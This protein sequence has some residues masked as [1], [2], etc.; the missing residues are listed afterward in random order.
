MG[1]AHA[2]RDQAGPNVNHIP[3]DA[4][5]YGVI[6]GI[7]HV[8]EM[9]DGPGHP[10]SNY[11]WLHAIM[12]ACAQR[13]VGVLLVGETGN[14]TVSYAGNGS[15]LRSLLRGQHAWLCNCSCMENQ[16]PGACSNARCS[17]RSRR[18]RGGIWRA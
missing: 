10:V 15:A 7:E 2:T 5:D 4:R 9:H 3:I 11:F 18:R 14:F 6:A 17:S 12:D 8:L 13:G 1:V 16:T